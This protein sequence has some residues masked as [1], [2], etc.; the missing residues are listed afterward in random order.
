MTA[1]QPTPD[2]APTPR[3]A[4][5]APGDPGPDRPGSPPSFPT[6]PGY[7]ATPGLPPTSPPPGDPAPEPIG[8]PAE[9][10]ADAPP[11]NTDAPAAPSSRPGAADG[12]TTVLGQ[13]EASPGPGA[14][15]PADQPAADGPTTVLGSADRSPGESADVA[16]AKPVVGPVD[17]RVGE[18]PTVV[19]GS[20]GQPSG[21]G[22]GDEPTVVRGPAPGAWAGEEPTTLGQAG[23]GGPPGGGGSA[24]GPGGTF[25][26]GAGGTFGGGPGGAAPGFSGAGFSGAGFSG[27]GGSGAPRG[28]LRRASQRKVVA[29]VARGLGDYTGVDPVLYRVV[30]AVLAL[31]GGTGVL[32]Y[33]IGWLFLPADDKQVSPAES[34]IGRGDGSSRLG[35]AAKAGLLVVIGLFLAGVLAAGDAGDVVLVLLVIGAVVYIVRNLSERRGEAPPDL[36]PPPVAYQP[37]E[38]PVAF[39]QRPAGGTAT[40]VAAPPVPP[41]PVFVP[42]QP[43]PRRAYSAL[44]MITLSA[45]LIVLGIAAALE[46][47]VSTKSYLALAT[48]VIGAGLVIGAFVGRARWLTWLGLPVLAALI[49]IGSVDLDLSGGA[50][51]RRYEPTTL[52]ELQNEYRVGVG[53]V[54][55]DLSALTFTDGLTTIVASAGVG[56]V[57]VIVPAGADVRI[58]GRAGIGEIDLLGNKDNGTSAD[59]TVVDLAPGGDGQV[60]LYLDL[61]I[62][63][64]KV[65]VTRA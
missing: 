20:A 10:P 63:V 30:F 18:E 50:G 52:A 44:G 38:Q 29:G 8:T 54:R 31:F 36:A 62:N 16:G 45:L 26:S 6:P 5:G 55:L 34:L 57:E 7:T 22:V 39:E 1:D 64:G 27:A 23:P 21:V 19:L 51:D 14:A 48:G 4:T 37:Y 42:P 43:R 13:A 9:P 49:V 65:E 32:L 33:I 46:G 35:D 15:P 41:P 12:P 60:D 2:D 3:G 58:E 24:G 56:N 47:D 40:A 17:G 53:N 59:R 25:G 61:D 11:T 28:R